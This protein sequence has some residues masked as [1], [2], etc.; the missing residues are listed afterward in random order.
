VRQTQTQLLHHKAKPFSKTYLEKLEDFGVKLF[1]WQDSSSRSTRN[2]STNTLCSRC[3][4]GGSGSGFTQLGS[5]FGL[6]LLSLLGKCF[7]LSGSLSIVNAE[8]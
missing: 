8:C 3:S 5:I 7:S 4:R 6:N 2:V 1:L